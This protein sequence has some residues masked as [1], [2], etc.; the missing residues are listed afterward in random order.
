V[1]DRAALILL[2]RIYE[3]VYD[4][5]ESFE[6]DYIGTHMA[7]LSWEIVRGQ[8]TDALTVDWTTADAHPILQIFLELFAP[9]DPVWDYIELP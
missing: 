9:A 1:T 4:A 6:L 8:N 5:T 7:Y 2:N 3:A